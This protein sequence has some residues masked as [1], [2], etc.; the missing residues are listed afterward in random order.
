MRGRLYV[1]LL[2]GQRPA[3]ISFINSNE[4]IH[5]IKDNHCYYSVLL[6]YNSNT[7]SKKKSPNSPHHLLYQHNFPLCSITDVKAECAKG[8]AKTT[9]SEQTCQS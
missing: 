5:I 3:G 1:L 2:E 6:Y 4:I 9:L 7:I 8:A